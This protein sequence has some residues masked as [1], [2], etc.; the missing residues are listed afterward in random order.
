MNVILT[1]VKVGWKHRHQ[2]RRVKRVEVEDGN[3]TILSNWKKIGP[4]VRGETGSD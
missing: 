1:K 4:D 3:E 2:G